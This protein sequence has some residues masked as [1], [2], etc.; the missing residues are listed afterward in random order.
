MQDTAPAVIGCEDWNGGPKGR[1]GYRREPVCSCVSVAVLWVTAGGKVE[2]DRRWLMGPPGQV[3]AA[4]GSCARDR[5]RQSRGR[6]QG[7]KRGRAEMSK[8]AAVGADNLT[9]GYLPRRK[10]VGG[11]A[12]GPGAGGWVGAGGGPP[13]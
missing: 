2:A 8:R 12:P 5:R 4:A 9:I 3:R 7:L 6:P 10:N 13:S 1:R 11:G